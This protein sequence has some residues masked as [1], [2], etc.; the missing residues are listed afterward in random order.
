MFGVK[1]S[2]FVKLNKRMNYQFSL[3]S[4]IILSFIGLFQQKVKK[5]KLY[6]ISAQFQ[7]KFTLK[8][9]QFKDNSHINKLTRRTFKLE[10]KVS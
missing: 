9:T 5:G 4:N 1:V 2:F 10:E 6:V 7:N 8:R 3:K